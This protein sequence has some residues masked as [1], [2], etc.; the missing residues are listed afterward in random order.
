MYIGQTSNFI[1]RYH[2]H[3]HKARNN[4]NATKGSELLLSGGS[5]QMLWLMPE[6]NQTERER[7]ESE[8]I[9][10]YSQNEEFNCLNINKRRN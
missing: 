4:K 2:H 9:E 7:I 8:T 1:Y 5:M 10:R 3:L 6:S